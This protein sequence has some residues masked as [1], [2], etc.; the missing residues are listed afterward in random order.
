VE[1]RIAL[2]F[3]VAYFSYLLCEFAAES[4]DF[5][6]QDS[7]TTSEPEARLPYFHLAVIAR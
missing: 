7:R 4:P 2:S 5:I 6:L 1:G 3:C